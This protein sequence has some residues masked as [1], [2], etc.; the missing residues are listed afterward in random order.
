MFYTGVMYGGWAV[1][2]ILYAVVF[3]GKATHGCV[4]CSPFNVPSNA[5]PP[6]LHAEG[7]LGECGQVRDGRGA[8]GSE[9]AVGR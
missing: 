9:A 8:A 4:S 7:I 3:E 5:S 1:L 2:L 6:P